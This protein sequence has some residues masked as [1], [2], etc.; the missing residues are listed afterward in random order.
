MPS[1]KTLK[2]EPDDL[3]SVIV[4][5]R[6]ARRTPKN[7]PKNPRHSKKR[8]SSHDL[9]SDEETK[10]FMNKFSQGDK[11]LFNITRA[12]LARVLFIVHSLVT[13]WQTTR[14]QNEGSFWAFAFISISIVVEGAHT[15]I[16]RFGDERK[17]FSP[18]VFLYICATAPPIWL[19]ESKLCEWRVNKQEGM[20]NEELY[21]QM[22]EQLLLVG[23]IVGRW[24]LPRGEVSQEQLS[25]IL[26]AYLAISSDIVE[27]FDVFKEKIVYENTRI[28]FIVLSA[29]SVSLF[30][31]TFI[32]TNS[33]ARKMR[34]AITEDEEHDK[35]VPPTQQK[36]GLSPKIN[37][38]A[39][40]RIKAG[41]SKQ[42]RELEVMPSETSAFLSNGRSPSVNSIRH[43]LAV[44]QNYVEYHGKK[45]SHARRHSRNRYPME[46]L[47]EIDNEFTQHLNNE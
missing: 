7:E 40:P 38:Q 14:I 10:F 36:K 34:V 30:Q 18:S 43:N 1:T 44:S 47:I 35:V 22:L 21:L 45:T 17:W 41:G 23:L 8:D 31:F 27:F 16:M 5:R 33:K 37:K 39:S 3:D 13:I 12:I 26:L 9:L 6:K 25:Q 46:E 42:L 32:L 15:I 11:I 24:L 29:W 4:V 19:M 20:P 28:Q 2:H